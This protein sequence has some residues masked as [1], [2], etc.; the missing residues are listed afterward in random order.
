[1]EIFLGE[2]KNA[3]TRGNFFVSFLF[4]NEGDLWR[5]ER[6]RTKLTDENR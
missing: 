3:Q 2:M 4:E 5:I 1:V 6:K